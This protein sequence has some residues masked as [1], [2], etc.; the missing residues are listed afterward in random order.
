MVFKLLSSLKN[1]ELRLKELDLLMLDSN[2]IKFKN[3][4][5]INE[6]LEWSVALIV[7][8]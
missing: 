1:L 7:M 8:Y 2:N 5:Y 3:G 6:A 4:E